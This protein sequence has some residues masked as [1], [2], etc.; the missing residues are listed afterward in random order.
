MH[1]KGAGG[2]IMR[3]H[4]ALRNTV[5]AERERARPEPDGILDCLLMKSTAAGLIPRSIMRNRVIF[6]GLTCDK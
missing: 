4:F 2:A 3:Q 5:Q 1:R 6:I